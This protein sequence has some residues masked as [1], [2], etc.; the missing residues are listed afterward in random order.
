MP[1]EKPGTVFELRNWWNCGLNVVGTSFVENV[2]VI[3]LV[4]LNILVQFFFF[5]YF[6][7]YHI[8][9]YMQKKKSNNEC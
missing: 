8:H 6:Q 5:F 9:Y 4:I 3:S 7:R 1:T 2:H